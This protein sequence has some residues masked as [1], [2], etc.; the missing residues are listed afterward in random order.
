MEIIAV[1]SAVTAQHTLTNPTK[2]IHLPTSLKS[3]RI[4]HWF[5][6]G[7]SSA[8]FG[9]TL[10]GV[11]P[12]RCSK[13]CSRRLRLTI[14]SFSRR[15]SSSRVDLS[16]IAESSCSRSSRT[17]SIWSVASKRDR[18]NSWTLS[19]VGDRPFSG[20]RYS[21]SVFS[22]KVMKRFSRCSPPCALWI[23]V[24]CSVFSSGLMFWIPIGFC[25][26]WSGLFFWIPIGFCGLSSGLFFWIPVF[27]LGLS[28][29][30]LLCCFSFSR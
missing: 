27:C 19:G 26:L 7:D 30:L 3:E 10:W 4:P 22:S 20:S 16:F 17:V 11:R 6:A 23:P 2:H 18:V 21:R 24:V 12:F 15:F 14:K 25:G 28:S 9:V 8:T 29:G 5:P 13:S 1:I